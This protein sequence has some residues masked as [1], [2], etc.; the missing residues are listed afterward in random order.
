M[1]DRNFIIIM[2]PTVEGIAEEN[3]PRTTLPEGTLVPTQRGDVS[4]ESLLPG[5]E[6]RT[7][8]LFPTLKVQQVVPQEQ[9]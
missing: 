7:N 1:A 4:V 2:I 3:Y 5:D 6:V 9:E 8:V